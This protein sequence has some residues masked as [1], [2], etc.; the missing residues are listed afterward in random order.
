MKTVIK[1]NNGRT[2]KYNCNGMYLMDD[3][4]QNCLMKK[5]C[6]L[7]NEEMEEIIRE[8]SQNEKI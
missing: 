7:R 4:C 8:N 2:R 5:N 6:E 1:D 3:M